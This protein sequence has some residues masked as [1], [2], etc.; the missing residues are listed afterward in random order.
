MFLDVWFGFWFFVL[1]CIDCLM[2]ADTALS[3]ALLELMV[4]EVN[5]AAVEGSLVDLFVSPSCGFLG[6]DVMRDLK[7]SGFLIGGFDKIF[8]FLSYKG[9]LGGG[10]ASV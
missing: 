1:N 6:R 10:F 9:P 3:A 8:V 2:V 4:N 5:R 7:F